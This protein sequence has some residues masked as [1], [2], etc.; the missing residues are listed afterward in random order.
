MNISWVVADD[1]FLAPDINIEQLKG[2]GSIWGSWKT[3]RSCQTDNVICSDIGQ[4]RELIQRNF[5]NICNFFVPKDAFVDLDRPPKVQLFDGKFNFEIDRPDELIT[6]HLAASRSDIVLLLGFDWQP[7][8]KKPDR[9]QEHRAQ[10]YY[11][12][13][14]HV[15]K[16][17]PT[18]QWVL[19]D[20]PDSILTELVKL[21]NLT[22]DTLANVLEML[23]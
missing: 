17:N 1:T 6:L 20:H 12:G 10:N 16:D 13:V 4:A 2:V 14:K 18:T 7:K 21:D 5:N 22:R 15:I 19:I 9:L 23:G 3:W 8:D 11:M